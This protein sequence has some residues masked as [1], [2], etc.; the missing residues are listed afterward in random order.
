[1]KRSKP[2]VMVAVLLLALGVAV[3]ASALP[4]TAFTATSGASGN[5]QTGR[6]SRDGVPSDW[7]SLKAF[8]GV[9]GAATINYTAY[10]ILGSMFDFGLG[11]Y[12]GYVQISVD[13]PLTS[14]FSSAYKNSYDPSNMALNYLGDMGSSGNVFGFP[15]SFQIY[16][17]PGDNLVLLFN[18]LSFNAGLTD[19]LGVLVEGF[20]DTMYTDPTQGVPEPASSLL[21]LGVGLVGLGT[22]RRRLRR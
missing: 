7:S 18:N 8:P 22:V 19:P 1:M 12:A 10:T 21:L 4:I 6:L 5:T 20:V 2:L 11:G 17:A 16:V 15:R 3:P 9:F 14:A 13:D